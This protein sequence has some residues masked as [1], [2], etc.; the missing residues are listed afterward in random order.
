MGKFILFGFVEMEHPR[1]LKGTKLHVQR[2][3]FGQQD[4]ELPRNF[5]DFIFGRARLAAKNT[6]RFQSGNKRKFGKLMNGILVVPR[7]AKL[8]APWITMF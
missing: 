3:R 7:K 1:R 5:G 2:G 8:S 6:L 4:I